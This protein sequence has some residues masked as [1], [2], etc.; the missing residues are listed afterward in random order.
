MCAGWSMK[1]AVPICEILF[2]SYRFEY[3]DCKKNS[4]ILYKLHT[5]LI[6]MSNYKLYK[7]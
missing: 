7:F 6:K 4:E 2:G 5:R 1:T 3:G